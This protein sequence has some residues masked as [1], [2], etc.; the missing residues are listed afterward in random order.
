[1]LRSRFLWKLYAGYAL[2]ILLSSAFVGGLVAKRVEVETLDETDDRLRTVAL[3]VRDLVLLRGLEAADVQ[4]QIHRLGED[5]DIRVTVVR[6]DGVVVADSEKDPAHMENHAGRPEIQAAYRD[7]EGRSTRFS[8]TLGRVLRYL[9]TPLH[10]DGEQIGVIRT[11]LPLTALESRLVDVRR[12]V[13]LGAVLAT[14][15]ALFVGF[16]Y[17]RRVTRPILSMALAAEEIAGGDY[18]QRVD[19]PGRDELGTLARAFNTMTRELRGSISAMEADRNKLTAILS[20]MV[21]GVVAVDRDERIVHI[22]EVAAQLLKVTSDHVLARPIWE[23]ARLHEA[24]EL[25]GEVL[26]DAKSAQRV[27]RM[28]GS[29]ERVVELRA[30]PLMSDGRLSGALLVLEDV[31][32]LRHLETMRRDFVGN[33]SHELK[34]PV[35]VIRGMVETMIDDPDMPAETRD[36]FLAKVLTQAERMGDLVTDLLS[37][38]HIEAAKSLAD[39]T[40]LDLRT[41]TLRAVCVHQP[42]ADGR[43]VTIRQILPPEPVFTLGDEELLVQAVGNLLSNAIKYSPDGGSVEVRLT[44]ED[45]RAVI[46]VED[47]GPG[48]EARHQERL[49]ERFYRVDKARSRELGGTGLGLAIVKHIALSMGGAVS[50]ESTP[51]KGSTFRIHLPR[52]QRDASDPGDDDAS[53]P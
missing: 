6:L 13:F 47:R 49:F 14:V 12:A 27:L 35:T 41:G 43:G 4:T 22:N 30:S 2:V 37:L 19:S 51:G 50:V 53:E 52:F 16:L 26:H 44:V 32:Q 15:A 7:G 24:S 5:I 23:I 34:T 25:L 18:E 33:V 29:P 45:S 10:V 40:P 1:M 48:I 8:K 36:R 46:A 3:V 20:S 39:R 9:A 28:P 42:L 31:T 38:A 11:A 17:A 21:E